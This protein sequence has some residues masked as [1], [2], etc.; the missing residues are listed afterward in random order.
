[1]LFERYARIAKHGLTQFLPGDVGMRN[2]ACYRHWTRPAATQDFARH[3]AALGPPDICIDCGA[4][5]GDVTAR[6]AAAA[7]HVHAFEPDPWTHLQLAANVGHLPNVTLHA[8]GVGPAAGTITLYRPPGFAADPDRGSLSTSIFA[9]TDSPAPT[10]AND[11]PIID[12]V[13]FLRDLDRDVAIVKMDIE[14]AEVALLDRLFDDPVMARI[15]ALYVETHELQFDHLL[16]PTADLRDRARA[17][18]GSYVNLDW[19]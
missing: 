13:G 18:R 5:R 1:M 4:N 12:F 16:R 6:L 17:I 19:H 11:V 15:G 2:R 8:C 10:D 9:R 7:G 14:G 3:L